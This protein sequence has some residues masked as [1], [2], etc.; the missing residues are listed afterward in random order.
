M[1]LSAGLF[2]H[3]PGNIAALAVSLSG[4][5]FRFPNVGGVEFCDK[6]LIPEGTKMASAIGFAR[7]QVQSA[8]TCNQAG[9]ACG[10]TSQSQR[11]PRRIIRCDECESPCSAMCSV[12][13]RFFCVNH[14]VAYCYRLLAECEKASAHGG[15]TESMRK[16]LRESASQATKLLLMGRQLQNLERA[17]LFDIVLWANELF[18]R[19]TSQFQSECDGPVLRTRST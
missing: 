13:L 12:E 11:T 17:R 16:F 3:C 2:R 10:E 7:A 1:S 15:I 6:Q 18:Y 14:F 5:I 4:S 19:S 9:E 8:T